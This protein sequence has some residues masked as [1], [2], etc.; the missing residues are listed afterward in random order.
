MPGSFGENFPYSN[1]HDL[2]MDWIIKIAKDFLDQYTHIQQIIE[3]GQEDITNLTEENLQA[4]TDKKD[5]LEALL[6]Q[7][8]NTHSSDIAVQ[9][10]NAVTSF[11]ASATAKT[12]EL[13][14]TIPSDYTDFF[15][16]TVV[17]LGEHQRGK[18]LYNAA[19]VTPNKEYNSEGA[20]VDSSNY[21]TDFIPVLPLPIYFS[22]NDAPVPNY[23]VYYAYEFDRNKTWIRRITVVT[24]TN[25]T[26]ASD[27][28]YVRFSISP[29]IRNS[30]MVEYFGISTFMYYFNNTDVA[31]SIGGKVEAD[32]YYNTQ[33]LYNPANITYKKE[34]NSNGELIDSTTLSVSNYI[35]ALKNAVYYLSLNDN[36]VPNYRVY[37]AYEFSNKL[38]FIRRRAIPTEVTFTPSSDAFYFRLGLSNGHLPFFKVEINQRTPWSK[39]L[40]GYQ[41]M[42]SI[43]DASVN[44]FDS[45]AGVGDSYTMALCGNQAGTTLTEHPEQS[46]IATM[47]KRAGVPWYL[48]GRSGATS[49]SFIQQD[50]QSLL[51]SPAR[52]LY[53]INIGQNDINTGTTE[54]TIS[55][56]HDDN[57]SLNPDTYYGNMGKII[58]AIKAH[59]PIA[60]IVLVKSW[61]N[62]NIWGTET[63]YQKLDPAIQNIADHF[64]IPTIAPYDDQYF[65]S[66]YHNYRRAQGHPSI[67]GYTMMGIAMERLFSKCVMENYNYF[68]Y[69]TI[70]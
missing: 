59:A 42:N 63:S 41:L 48:Y 47:G 60:K 68:M 2:N 13:L 38:N 51:D 8:Y 45:I 21:L 44:V 31:K 56:I 5:E 58:A 37:Y 18:N 9:L 40:P 3:Q 19:T 30:L 16:D 28:V 55:D 29:N 23:R 35:P 12:E 7:W 26:P 11:N 34:Y 52:G 6:D 69:S 39:A 20:I 36:P 22:V 50:L 4:L 64:G 46:Y 54:G 67:L 10:A 57:P 15:D 17:N 32:L 61:V 65:N 27:A 24:A 33:N 43:I 49:S 66:Y 62:H 25:Y 70:G 53:I 14:G 1:F